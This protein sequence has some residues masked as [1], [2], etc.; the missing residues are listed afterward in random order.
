MRGILPAIMLAAA[1]APAAAAQEVSTELYGEFRYS[2]NR[3]DAGDSTYWASANNTSRIGLRGEITEAGLTAFIDMQAGVNVDAED[4]GT[5]FTQRY[6]LAGVRGGFGTITVG[7][8]STA[9][10]VPGV[11]LD[12]FY[13]TSTLSAGGGVP[14]T[15]AFGGATFGLSPLS[16][17]WSQRAL[18]YNSPS[19][20]GVSANAA[21]YVDPDSDH[22]YAVGLGYLADGFDAGVQYH[23]ADGARNWTQIGVVDHALRGHVAYTRPGEWSLGA[24]Y[25]RLEAVIG[26]RQDYLYAAGT[27]NVVPRVRLAG[28]LGHVSEGAVQPLSGLGYQGGIFVT[29]VPGAE[30]H[31]LYS[32]ADLDAVDDRANLAL[33]LTYA[34]RVGW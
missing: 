2:Y 27:W 6:Y 5:A 1:L 32:R 29:L 20:A 31:A 33:G 17:G 14:V 3:A 22:D 18:A 11:R 4:A 8:H 15:G 30:V 16:N 13:D 28:S 7:R 23:N 9:Y 21:I 26:D 10:K 19:F 12:P 25:E 34:F 24:T